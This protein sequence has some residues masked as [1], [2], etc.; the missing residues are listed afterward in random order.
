MKSYGATV[1]HTPDPARDP[2]LEPCPRRGPPGHWP[3]FTTYFLRYP[4]GLREVVRVVFGASGPGAGAFVDRLVVALHAADG[5]L[6]VERGRVLV[7]SDPATQVVFAYWDDPEAHR[8]WVASRGAELDGDDVAWWAETAEL[9]LTHTETHFGVRTRQ[10]GLGRIPGTE[11]QFCPMVGYWGSA[12]DRIPASADDELEPGAWVPEA[13]GDGL[14]RRVVAPH[15]VA[16]IRTSQDWCDAPDDHVEW[17]RNEVEPTLRAG[18][19]HLC[20]QADDAGCISARYVRET[21][22]DGRDVDRT[23]V[24]ASFRSLGDLERWARDHPTHHAIF[25]S[26]MEM[27]RRF[28]EQLGIRLFHEVSVLPEGR[29]RGRYRGDDAQ[30]GLL[31]RLAADAPSRS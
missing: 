26:G 13:V 15:N 7:P 29:Y 4:R 5:A 20:A 19:E 14:D 1:L 25:V 10:T 31:R 3:D 17:Y 24:L 27:V 23:C 2:A 30:A 21:D 28:G 18:V 22:L 16:T 9:P 6:T 11:H 8:R 12:R